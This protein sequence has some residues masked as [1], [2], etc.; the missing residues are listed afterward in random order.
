[1]KLFTASAKA[2]RSIFSHWHLTLQL[3][4]RNIQMQYRGSYLGVVWTLL[5]PLMMLGIYSFVF[6][7]VFSGSFVNETPLQH[8]L[9]IFVG[10]AIHNFFAET[11]VLTPPLI[12]S[13]SSFVKKVVFPLE[14]LVIARLIA[15]LLTLAIKSA[16]ILAAALIMGNG[17]SLAHFGILAMLPIMFLMA[18]G[19]GMLF[20]SVGVVIK[21]LGNASQ[22]LSMALLFGSA[23][24]Y[25]VDKIP[26]G[27]WTYLQ[28]NP[29]V[30]MVDGIR[31]IVL[32][33]KPMPLESY[34]APAIAA[35][36]IF[37][38]G[39]YVFQKLR[40]SFPDYL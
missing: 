32:W 22:F 33:N 6:G 35:V 15:S 7:Y 8:A 31:D 13:H 38:L 40:P 2:V 20:A 30:Y 17:V 14:T 12:Q 26:P 28:F 16:L 3:A 10:L 1:M 37:L 29:L 27:A 5:S 39:N 4:A 24:F 36:I 25:P 23:V 9:G 34:V 11:I 19:I 18:T 21:D